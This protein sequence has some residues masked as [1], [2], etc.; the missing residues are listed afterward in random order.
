ME[1]MKKGFPNMMGKGDPSNPFLNV[2]GGFDVCD[3]DGT[4]LP[5]A[6]CDAKSN[7]PFGELESGLS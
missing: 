5:S 1:F 4:T 7:S 3:G 2:L 6:G